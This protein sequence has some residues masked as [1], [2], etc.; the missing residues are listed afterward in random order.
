MQMWWRK[1]KRDLLNANEDIPPTISVDSSSISPHHH[2]QQ[3]RNSI[4]LVLNDHY[5]GLPWLRHVVVL[6]FIFYMTETN[7]RWPRW[8]PSH[9]LA[10]LPSSHPSILLLRP[11]ILPKLLCKFEI[12]L[13]AYFQDVS[14]ISHFLSNAFARKHPNLLLFH[15]IRMGN[16]LHKLTD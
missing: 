2:H 15:S 4:V 7:L 12:I 9:P 3:Q 10:Q 14:H 13:N 5:D 16:Q 6:I 8:I 11:V 1:R